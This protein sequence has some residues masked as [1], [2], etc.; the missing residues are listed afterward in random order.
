MSGSYSKSAF[1]AGVGWVAF[2]LFTVIYIPLYV[3]CSFY[4]FMP[5]L[6][7]HLS[8]IAVSWVLFFLLVGLL[9]T[10]IWLGSG[11]RP[12]GEEP[13]LGPFVP[14]QL[15]RRTGI[16]GMDRFGF[17]AAAL[18]ALI[19]IG[20]RFWFPWVSLAALLFGGCALFVPVELWPVRPRRSI[21]EP[22][23]PHP[24][25]PE[26]DGEDRHWEWTCRC[27]P[28]KNSRVALRIARKTV[29]LRRQQNSSNG[30]L[31]PTNSGDV[32]H[33]L[34]CE[35]SEDREVI[36]AA[37]Q[38]L[39]FARENRFN[40]F[41]EAQN[42][43]QL[44]QVIPYADDKTSKGKEYFRFAVETL[45]DDVGDCDCKAILASSI[46]RLMGL[47]SVVLISW[48]EGHAAVAVEGAPDFE[49]DQEKKYF[50]SKDGKKYYYCETTDRSF[51]FTV[52]EVPQD[53]NLK[54]YIT[55][56]IEPALMAGTTH[57]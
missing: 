34:V 12:S 2:L 44:A 17:V 18:L 31:S 53:V 40:Y 15:S 1:I 48:K 23:S 28:E 24:I 46:F 8:W 35:G 4:S 30:A 11:A 25:G 42:T 9:L 27:R 22:P 33:N 41:E 50:E 52:G 43:L 55:V 36:E 57:V 26:E 29:D 13:R 14:S 51:G 54:D 21:P 3:M 19:A 32:I 16:A 56:D 37:R 38:L 49:K 5:F 20:N 10:V 6:G 39:S 45:Y 47:R 7:G